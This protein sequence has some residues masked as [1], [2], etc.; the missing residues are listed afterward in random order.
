MRVDLFVHWILNN[1]KA[2]PYIF[3]TKILLSQKSISGSST[4][5]CYAHS[6]KLRENNESE[7]KTYCETY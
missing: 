1:N 7:V 5:I 6:N 2:K 3:H 4:Y